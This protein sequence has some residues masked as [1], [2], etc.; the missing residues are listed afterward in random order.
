[1][2]T[3]T[4]NVTPEERRRELQRRRD[5]DR[6]IAGQKVPDMRKEIVKKRIDGHVTLLEEQISKL[7]IL[8]HSRIKKVTFG[9][10]KIRIFPG[11]KNIK[12]LIKSG[13]PLVEILEHVSGIPKMGKDG[14]I[15]LK[16]QQMYTNVRQQKTIKSLTPKTQI[17]IKNLILG[18]EKP[19]RKRYPKYVETEITE[20]PVIAVSTDDIELNE[21]TTNVQTIHNLSRK[22]KAEPQE[23]VPK[24][25][26]L[27]LEED[28]LP[29]LKTDDFQLSLEN[30]LLLHLDYKKKL[31][32]EESQKFS[33]LEEQSKMSEAANLQ[34][35]QQES[36]PKR[37]KTIEAIEFTQEE[38]E[39]IDQVLNLDFQTDTI[40]RQ[41]T[42]TVSVTP[43]IEG[44]NKNITEEES[45]LYDTLEE[46]DLGDINLSL[47]N[48]TEDTLD[49]ELLGE[50]VFGN[51]SIE[52]EENIQLFETKSLTTTT[53][54]QENL[55]SLGDELNLSPQEPLFDI[56]DILGTSEEW[57]DVQDLLNVQ[58]VED[59]AYIKSATNSQ[60]L[61]RHLREISQP[62]TQL[63]YVNE[64]EASNSLSEIPV[65]EFDFPEFNNVNNQPIGEASI[66][67]SG[68]RESPP[69]NVE[70]VE[71]DIIESGGSVNIQQS[72]TWIPEEIQFD[73]ELGKL[74]DVNWIKESPPRKLE[75]VEPY[76]LDSLDVTSISKLPLW[77]PERTEFDIEELAESND[78]EGLGESPPKKV[79]RLEYD[80]IESDVSLD[81]NNVIPS[82]SVENITPNI[83]ESEDSALQTDTETDQSVDDYYN[84]PLLD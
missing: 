66:D 70:I 46:I 63:S 14:K 8:R 36:I 33:G 28:E 84:M 6:K 81:V 1:M 27:V 60:E 5:L 73:T 2:Q 18:L 23:L 64:I 31:E 53:N 35:T 16:T 39:F 75:R 30:I 45:I 54:L 7:Q 34:F 59:V 37:A 80:F 42:S 40:K 61:G 67:M 44:L 77:T 11:T 22:T 83:I 32:Y 57:P 51:R 21:K 25:Q 76:N 68:I 48:M 58:T 4:Q 79:E 56:P 9:K 49:I 19:T 52:N 12:E 78:V 13:A 82:M 24:K 74:I 65:L 43:N 71:R 15:Y 47:N 17:P 62:F 10:P 20:P 72:L 41:P 69:R 38:N 50:C 26:S 55:I 3:S 29:I